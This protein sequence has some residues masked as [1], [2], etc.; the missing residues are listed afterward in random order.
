MAMSNMMAN[1]VTMPRFCRMKCPSWQ[2]LWSSLSPWSISGS[3]EGSM[4]LWWVEVEIV[5]AAASSPLEA[6]HAASTSG[7]T[8]HIHQSDIKEHASRDG[9]DPA[10]DALCVL[11][12]RRANQHADVG[13]EGRQQVVDDGLLHRHPRFQQHCEIT[14]QPEHTRSPKR[15]RN[16]PCTPSCRSAPTSF[17]QHAKPHKVCFSVPISSLLPINPDWKHQYVCR[18]VFKQVKHSATSQET[19]STPVFTRARVSPCILL[20]QRPNSQRKRPGFTEKDGGWPTF[21]APYNKR[22]LFS[23]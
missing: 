22:L 9:E 4:K 19:S 12:H 7:P 13:H 21:P 15:C 17:L 20:D 16:G 10:G 23:G 1:P 6:R 2:R 3:C 8:H 5:V 14:C 18:P 11:A